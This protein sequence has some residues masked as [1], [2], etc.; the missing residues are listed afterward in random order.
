MAALS[1]A[2]VVMLRESGE[3]PKVTCALQSVVISC[4]I[5]VK[6]LSSNTSLTNT[7]GYCYTA[8]AFLPILSIFALIQRIALCGQINFIW[9][10]SIHL[11]MLTSKDLKGL[12]ISLA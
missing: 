4:L 2:C 6:G 12:S 7:V 1:G 9:D 3:I 5:E 10:I 8:I 11:G